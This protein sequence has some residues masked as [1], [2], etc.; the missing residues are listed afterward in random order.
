MKKHIFIYG[1]IA[2][3]SF[4]LI[5]A[6]CNLKDKARE[7]TEDI[8]DEMS[9]EMEDQMDD[10]VDDD[11][12][13][14]SNFNSSDPVEYND[15]VLKYY[16]EL[17]EQIAAFATAIMDNTH[18]LE[19]LEDEYDYTMQIYEDNYDI[20]KDIEPLSKDPG[21]QPSVEKFYEG[22]KD[23]LDNEYKEILELIE[24][25][26]STEEINEVNDKILDKLIS[27]ENDVIDAQQEFA[28]EYD[29]SLQ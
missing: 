16:T 4:S 23:A 18:T 24:D 6:G 7:K 12:N 25:D 2:I 5:F 8:V 3:F 22:V 17:D 29:I 13:S 20:V 21:F 27:L 15:Y 19:E 9:D 1:F 10:I 26:A 14:Q 28:D 11:D